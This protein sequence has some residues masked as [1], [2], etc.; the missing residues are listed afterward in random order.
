MRTWFRA[1]L[2]SKSFQVY[3]KKARHKLYMSIFIQSCLSVLD[4]FGIAAIGLIGAMSVQGIQSNS[5]PKSVD[6]ILTILNFDG[7]TFQTQVALLAILATVILISKTLISIV[8][9]RRIYRFMSNQS[10]IL[11][12]DLFARILRQPLSYITTLTP[13]KIL[14]SVTAGCSRVTLGIT[15]NYISVIVD[16]VLLTLLFGVLLFVDIAMTLSIGFFFSTAIILFH[17]LIKR[18]AEEVGETES[19]LNIQSNTLVLEGIQSYRERYVKNTLPYLTDRFFLVRVKLSKAL[20]ESAFLPNVTKYLIESLVLVGAL[21]VCGIQ[22]AMNDAAEAIAT[23]SIFI[24][25]ATRVTPAIMRMQQSLIQIRNSKGAAK[26]ALDLIEYLQAN[27]VLQTVVDGAPSRENS[28]Q[29]LRMQEVSFKYP[30]SEHLAVNK[31]NLGLV[32]GESIALVGPSGGGKS[33]IADLILGIAKPTTGK[34]EVFNQSPR[35]VIL[36]NKGAIGYVPQMTSLLSDTL[37]ENLLLGSNSPTATDKYLY[38]I[39][40]AVGLKE[41]FEALGL[42][43]NTTMGESGIKLSGGQLQR[44][45]IARALVTQPSFL[46]LDEATSSLDAT[47]ENTIISTLN[48]LQGKIS[49]VIIA[50]RLSTIRNVN[51]IYYIENGEV[52]SSGTFEQLRRD[53]NDFDVQAKLMGL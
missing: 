6:K 13:N 47:S 20:A 17:Q 40:E 18:K 49:M 34:I 4:L 51:K 3:E 7:F 35:D 53:V 22:F 32:E 28:E 43:L 52:I 33:T 2:I 29:V 1:T 45:G 8:A 37:R 46:V 23:L 10:A 5:N 36:Q 12:A 41:E 9:I 48:S 19:N 21:L 42:N 38:S 27:E 30:G 14:Y 11:A 50:H 39:L 24:G 44:L 31:V 26:S 25:A 15:G 16:G